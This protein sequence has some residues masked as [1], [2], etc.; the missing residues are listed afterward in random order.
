MEGS[1]RDIIFPK[2]PAPQVQEYD[3][4]KVYGNLLSEFAKAFSKNDPLFKLSIYYPFNH[5]VI[6]KD[7]LDDYDLKEGRLAGIVRLDLKV[8]IWRSK[9]LV[10]IYC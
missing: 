7:E 2:T 9:F 6:P 8:H 3:L 5:L 1:E 4:E 10:I